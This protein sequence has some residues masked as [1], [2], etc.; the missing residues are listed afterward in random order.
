[1]HQ[2]FYHTEHTWR[3]P[4]PER[5]RESSHGP[6]HPG[7]GKLFAWTQGATQDDETTQHHPS[8]RDGQTPGRNLLPSYLIRFFGGLPKP[9][10]RQSLRIELRHVKANVLLPWR[11]TSRPPQERCFAR[12]EDQVNGVFRLWQFHPEGQ[13]TMDLVLQSDPN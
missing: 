4:N 7:R 2:P 11:T 6:N 13:R 8:R 12:V 1:M 3:P 5:E 10:H 9:F